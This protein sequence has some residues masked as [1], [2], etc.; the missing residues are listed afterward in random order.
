MDVLRDTHGLGP[1]TLSDIEE[2]VHLMELTVQPLTLTLT[3]TPNLNPG[4]P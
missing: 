3:L 2:M 1:N 4:E